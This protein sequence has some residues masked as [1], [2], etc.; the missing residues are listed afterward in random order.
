MR[1]INATWW[2]WKEFR[3]V[4]KDI[5]LPNTA[6]TE[7][8]PPIIFGKSLIR[9]TCF[10]GIYIV[11]INLRSM[12]ELF[13]FEAKKFRGQDWGPGFYP[14]KKSP[15]TWMVLEWWSLVHTVI[16][17]TCKCCD[18]TWWQKGL[19]RCD[20]AKD[21]ERGTLVWIIEGLLQSQES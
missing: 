17:Q 5:C 11:V 20:W 21:L 6:N 9:L 1:K 13:V 19:C 10:H 16:L 7:K 14:W 4:L 2:H 18:H 3:K 12:S 8:H 15:K